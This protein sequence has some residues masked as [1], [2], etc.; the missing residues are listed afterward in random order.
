MYGYEGASVNKY[1]F[2][3][4]EGIHEFCHAFV[5]LVSKI[6]AKYPNGIIKKESYVKIIW[7]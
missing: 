2:I 4:H 3:K 5:D 6:F 7:D 1:S